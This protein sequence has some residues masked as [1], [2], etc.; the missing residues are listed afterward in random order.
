MVPYYQ[1]WKCMNLS[2]D[3][4]YFGIRSYEPEEHQLIKDKNI[5]VFEAADC[6]KE[7]IGAIQKELSRYFKKRDNKYWI[8]FDIDS[9][10]SRS[11]KS[12]GTAEEDGLTLEFVENFFQSMAGQTVGM[13]FTEV[14]FELASSAQQR[15]DDQS[16]FRHLLE[17][18]CHSINSTPAYDSTLHTPSV[19]EPTLLG[20]DSQG[21]K[22]NTFY[23]H[24][25][26]SRGF[27][28]KNR[29]RY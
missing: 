5:L 27:S 11:F 26:T 23:K 10:D 14:N 19:L 21:F 16:T 8:S 12:T 6:L 13:D 28:I 7:N 9:V 1:Q 3:L 20:Y 4:C 25:P 29:S 15:L 17:L 22:D 2:K 24:A 18:I